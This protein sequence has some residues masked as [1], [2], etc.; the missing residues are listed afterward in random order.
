MQNVFD[1]LL[2]ISNSR[3]R[4]KVFEKDDFVITKFSSGSIDMNF[5]INAEESSTA[6]EVAS[7]FNQALSSGD[8]ISGFAISGSAVSSG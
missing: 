7:D 5:L 1:W 3:S 6:N 4:Q 2:K 8:S